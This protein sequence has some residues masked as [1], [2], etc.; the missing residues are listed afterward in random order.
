[1]DS[2]FYQDILDQISD[3]VY[4]VTRDRHITYW[5]G[6]AQRITGFDAGDV[7]GHSCAEGILRHVN[8]AGRQLCVHGCPL[9]GVMKD[10]LPRETHIYLHHKDGHRVPVTVR[11]HPL[12]NSD[13]KVVGAV[14]VFSPRVA[15]MY[16]GRRSTD[17]DDQMDP[18]TGLP[19]RRLGELHLRTLMGA[20]A[21]RSTTLGVL[22]IDAD[23][24]KAI[25]DTF[26]HKAGDD[27]LR[28]VAQSTANG[29]RHG[30]I[31]VR[32]G[33]EEFLVMLPG[34]DQRG[35][36]ATAE[37][38]RML[39]EN[40]WIQRG[41]VQARVT[42]SIGATLAVPTESTDEL[43][44]RSDRLMYA[45]KNAGRNR[46]TTDTGA[47][48]NTSERPILGTDIPWLMPGVPDVDGFGCG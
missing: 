17:N 5:N 9:A 38:V 45:S 14:E 19:P 18:V 7:L 28:M 34:I 8:D 29:L 22:F 41:A 3:G 46:V 13:G 32:W 44:D 25:N 26:G 10:G 15:N 36:D 16:A 21:E 4:F 24:F 1:M 35:L 2:Q 30:D 20:V 11:G 37:R 31:P 33:G 40:S 23:H 47:L 12:R 43:L 6:G 39:V 27:V 42:V 48:T